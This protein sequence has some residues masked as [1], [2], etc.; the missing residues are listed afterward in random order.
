MH[1]HAENNAVKRLL[2]APSYIGDILGWHETI[3]VAGTGPLARIYECNALR[4]LHGG[5]VAIITLCEIYD[6]L[7]RRASFPPRS[8]REPC[9]T[10]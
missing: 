7:F 4:I 9:L 10:T 1:S 6:V 2:H 8:H 5:G 3:G